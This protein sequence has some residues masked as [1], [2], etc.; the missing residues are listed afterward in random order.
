MLLTDPS[1]RELALAERVA[2]VLPVLRAHAETADREGMFQRANLVALRD[3]GLLG[4]IVPESFGG[5]GGGLRDLASATYAMG[6]ACPSTA[7]AYFFHCSAASRG[8]LGLEAIEAGLFHD[9]EA[10]TVREF[11]ERLL[12]R[13]GR[14]QCWLANFA[15]ESAKSSAAAINISTTAK[16]VPGG[17]SLSGVKSFGCGTGV[18]D[19][20]LVTAMLD[21]HSTAEGLGVFFVAR[22]AA[23]VGVRNKWDAIGMRATANDGITLDN[24]FVSEADALAIPGAFVKMMRMSRGS[25]VGNQ[26]AGTAIYLGAAQSV[27]DFAIDF[28]TRTKFED[29]GRPVAE[30]PMHQQLIG[31]M[32]ADLESAH[33]WLRR[34]IDL[35]ASETPSIPKDR[36]VMQW[37]LAKGEICEK[38]YAVALNA[39]K[40]CGTSNSANGG[41]IARGLRDLAMGLVQAFPAERGKLWAAE[42]VV[43]GREGA[44]FGSAASRG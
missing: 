42:T 30:S 29:T 11:A 28:L 26:L 17:W 32:T 33:L 6:G 19:W 35:E 10:Q 16:H 12:N 21:G 27:Y 25:F 15:S 13:M 14:E 40:A 37:R 41:V 44:S 20:Y 22:D 36:V 9:H 2:A 1:P 34:Q 7:L 43:K 24:V 18:A 38:A 23:G 8:L 31:Q 4:L 39:F 3:A 5:L